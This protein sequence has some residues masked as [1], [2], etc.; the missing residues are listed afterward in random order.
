M[1][2]TH[3]ILRASVAEP[4]LGLGLCLHS[5]IHKVQDPVHPPLAPALGLGVHQEQAVQDC[6]D[7]DP[8]L[9]LVPAPKCDQQ[10]AVLMDQVTL[11][12]HPLISYCCKV[13]MMILPQLEKRM[14]VT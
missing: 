1:C 8:T 9:G 4:T 3:H 10:V 5:V 12:L 11:T 14:Q 13:T 2:P 7:Q 6:H